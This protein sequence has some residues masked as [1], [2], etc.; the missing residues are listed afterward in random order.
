MS[1]FLPRTA[2]V[3]MGLGLSGVPVDDVLMDEALQRIERMIA[4]G[5]THHIA[6][7]NV[8]FLVHAA[9]DEEYRRMLCMCDLVVADGMPIVWASKLF[10][11]PLRERVTGS[12]LVPLLVHLSARK[13]YSIFL[14]GATAEVAE[15]AV[16][17]MEKS[18]PGVRVVGRMSPPIMPLDQIDSEAILAEIERAK[19]D[20]LLVAFGSPKQEKWISRNRHRLNVPVCIGIGATLDFMSGVVKRAPL[21]MQK[22]GFEW[23]YRMAVEPKRLGPRYFKDAVWMSRHLVLQVA[24]HRVR[25]FRSERLE[26]ALDVIGS[27]HVI[28]ISGSM[29]GSGLT[30][31]HELLSSAIQKQHPIVLDLTKTSHVGADGLWALAGMLRLADR[32]RCEVRLSGLSSSLQKELRAAGFG[33]LFTA[34]TCPMEA[35]RQVSRGRVQLNLEI[36]ENWALCRIAGDDIPASA[37]KAIEE[38]CQ[39]LRRVSEHFEIE[40]T[41]ISERRSVLIASSV[42]NLKDVSVSGNSMVRAAGAA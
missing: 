22:S 15:R 11:I 39:S 26:V 1:T 28:Q 19:P 34:A 7:A 32:H 9:K 38:I 12:D 31:L 40:T 27:V 6:T 30:K 18:A 25:S 14:L 33:G 29:A 21:W 41:S 2:T 36:G 16:R 37:R 24:L 23:L 17:Q 3:Q 13:G 35:I 10:G 20:I 5:G 8:D 42:A 4:D